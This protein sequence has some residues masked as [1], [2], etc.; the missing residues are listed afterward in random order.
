MKRNL[1]ETKIKIGNHTIKNRIVFPPLSCNWANPG[2]TVNNKIV[3]F[4]EETAEGGCGMVVVSGA[5]VREDGKATSRAICLYDTTHVP[6]LRKVSE[7]INKNNCFSCIQLL[8]VG[9]QGNPKFTGHQVVSPSGIMCK[10]LGFKSK[11]L[12]VKEIENIKRCFVNSAI[13]AYEAGFKAVELHLGHGYLLHEFISKHTNKRKDNYGGS[14]KKRLRIV[15][16]IIKDIRSIAPGLVIGA[17]ISGEDYVPDGIN[18]SYNKVILPILEKEGIGYFSVTAGI[19]E[20]SKQKHE[21]MKLGKFFEYSG[22]IK[23]F[24]RVPVIGVGKVLDMGS[25]EFHL[26]KKHCDMV[27]I[28][29]GQLSCPGMVNMAKRGI[30]LRKCIECNMCSYLRS[31]KKYLECPNRD[32]TLLKPRTI[33]VMGGARFHGL[34]LAKHFSKKGDDVYV[35]NRGNLRQDYDLKINRIV[36]DRNNP[37]EL[38][39]ALG[40]LHIDLV[41]DNNCYNAKQAA[42]ILRLIRHRCSQYIFTSSVAVY[43]KLYSGHKLKEEEATGRKGGGF[44]Q[45]VAD[46]A[47]NKLEAENE[48]RNNRH[49]TAFTIIRLPN[50]FGEGDFLGKLLYFYYRLKDKNKILLEKEVK[51]F[52]L[53]Y[54]KDVVKVYDAAAL[55]KA[56]FGK[57][58]NACDPA[59]YT[60]NEFFSSIYGRLYTRKKVF[61]AP[62]KKIS[63]KGYFFPFPWGPEV[64]TSLAER[65]IGKISYTPL[66]KWGK[67]T[68]DWELSCLDSIKRKADY[69]IAR[70]DEIK[71]ISDLENG[72]KHNN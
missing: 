11:K 18:I 51:R 15:T 31:G 60:Y 12:S 68:L 7:V 44:S 49:I 46:Y 61:L 64:D 69:R 65:L 30:S 71:V 6:G 23:K 14:I 48:I 40:N 33:L 3:R 25:A 1:W 9:G 63:A 20:T 45:R 42:I 19:Y 4:Y 38:K 66:A 37:S 56:C 36:A 62:S 27:A 54:A 39:S 8:H 22:A 10:S 59:P 50:V 47:S 70:K 58:I 72:K 17:R 52:S 53:I 2:G 26:K 28:G 5:S 41:I 32:I 67:A 29:R 34:L 43:Q 24:V 21:A 35:L 16:D 13:L 55:N 57:V